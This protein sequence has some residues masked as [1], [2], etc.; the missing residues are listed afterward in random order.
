MPAASTAVTFASVSRRYA[1]ARKTSSVMLCPQID[2]PGEIPAYRVAPI[3][4]RPSMRIA[5]AARA[6][7]LILLL[8]GIPH[9]D[10]KTLRY[11][12]QGDITTLDPHANNEG[13][14]NSFLDNVFET[15]ATRGKDLKVE[16]SLAL[17]W[18][19]V[20]PT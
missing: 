1:S 6:A 9:A 20:D 4:R 7:T 19:A 3:P 17:S 10:A 13:F 2:L 11:S 14:T 8:A 18:Q 16:P 15:L 5:T 12:S